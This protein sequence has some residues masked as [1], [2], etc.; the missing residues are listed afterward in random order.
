MKIPIPENESDRLE[1]L[2]RYSILDTDPEEAF[3]RITRIAAAYLGVP[4][5]LISLLDE[6]RQW[7]KSRHGLDAE[8]TPRDLAFCAHTIMRD[9]PMIVPD[10]LL[11]ARFRENPLV[12]GAPHVRF[13]AGAPLHTHD[14][15]NLGTLCAIDSIPK[16]L[17]DEQIC[18]LADLANLV[19]DELEL[20]LAGEQA[21]EE[22][23]SRNEIEDALRTTEER[24]R[25]IIEASSDWFWEMGPD[26]R[27]ANVSARFFEETGYRPEDIIGKT[28]ME[29]IGPKTIFHDPEMWRTHEDNLKH[30]KPFQ[31]FEY[32]Q[33]D[34]N[35]KRRYVSVSAKPFVNDNGKFLG[36]RGAT[37]DITDRK[38]A[39][40]ALRESEQRYQSLIE[41]SPVAIFV[42]MAGIIIFA[43]AFTAKF[44]GAANAD[45]LIGKPLM[46]FIAPE[47]QKI[48]KER[49]NNMIE[50]G[51]VAAPMEQK[52]IRVDGGIIYAESAA[53]PIPYQ[54]EGAI[55]VVFSDV[56]ERKY[57][58]EKLRAAKK[59]ADLATIAKS[60]FL[61][62]M[63]HELRTPLNAVIGL[64]ETIMQQVF[65]PIGHDKYAEYAVDIHES[66]QHLLQLIND[67]LDVS[68]I[69]AGKLELHEDNVKAVQVVEASIRLI[70]PRAESKK[71]SIR[72]DISEDLPVLYADE[73]R[74]KQIL[75]NLL[76]NAVKFSPENNEIFIEVGLA[77]NG[78]MVFVISDT[79]I[80]M[81][82]KGLAKAME[83]F[84]Q[85]D[86]TQ[87]R[88]FEGTGLGLP[89]S[90]SFTELHGGTLEIGSEK[91]KGTSVTVTF[92]KERILQNV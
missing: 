20:R 81:D 69:E 36:Y 3:D 65:G 42:H 64:S 34:V 56:T 66:G 29:F 7:F 44:L 37:R 68:A 80:G 2:K 25:D 59:A 78:S 11:D 27:Y 61:A 77:E 51:A 89:L 57:G 86:S 87:A 91:G 52:L 32:F 45:E 13:Y 5:V 73:R 72:A 24:M 90:R 35:G 31:N 62:T 88:K 67:I 46:E 15:F 49:I 16:T 79:G 17:T 48:V 85:I 6:T 10:A 58:E 14:G 23:A 41:L 53:T 4:T 21:Q 55:L 12:T 82:E 19:V 8:E 43:N 84:G 22:I 18:V 1:A 54:G 71:V 50:N 30:H 9:E 26:L 92:P 33:E 75:L 39:E 70:R 60:E 40:I 38:Q 28:R 63:S 74:L 47:F 76:S 83:P